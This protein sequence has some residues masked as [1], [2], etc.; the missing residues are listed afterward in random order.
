MQL[1]ILITFLILILTYHSN[2]HCKN[3]KNKYTSNLNAKTEK[4]ITNLAKDKSNIAS[5]ILIT[6]N[7]KSE[8]NSETEK[9]EQAIFSE[10]FNYNYAQAIALFKQTAKNLFLE[11]Q[12]GFIDHC[13]DMISGNLNYQDAVLKSFWEKMYSIYEEN[14]LKSRSES[15]PIV[16]SSQSSS[17]PKLLDWKNTLITEFQNVIKYVNF[18]QRL[19]S[20]CSKQFSDTPRNLF[21]LLFVLSDQKFFGGRFLVTN[22]NHQFMDSMFSVHRNMLP[23]NA[24]KKLNEVSAGYMDFNNDQLRGIMSKRSYVQPADNGNKQ[25]PYASNNN[26]DFSKTNVIFT[27]IFLIYIAFLVIYFTTSTLYFQQKK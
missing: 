22:K 6:S 23:D 14:Q 1:K 8:A 16:S 27:F 7:A 13:L 19:K 18:E 2:A 5:T 9:T 12:T 4:K 17:Y 3:M 10:N 24:F 25:S 26:F 20:D 15:N 21:D 11:K